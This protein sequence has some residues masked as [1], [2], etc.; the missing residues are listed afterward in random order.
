MERQPH[1]G[2]RKVVKKLGGEKQES[3]FSTPTR[4]TE[5]VNKGKPPK[6]MFNNQPPESFKKVAAFKLAANSPDRS[7]AM[8]RGDSFQ[9]YMVQEP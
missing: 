2:E 3:A 8:Q 5:S 4:A 6:L 1:S 7:K 9:A